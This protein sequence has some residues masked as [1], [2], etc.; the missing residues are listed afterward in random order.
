MSD[1]LLAAI[2]GVIE[3]LTEFLPVS[4]TAHL[5][6]S[7]VLMGINLKDPYWEMFSIVIQTGAILAVPIYFWSTIREFLADFPR[8]PRGRNTLLTHPLTL[9][10][11]AFVFT[12][13]PSL[14]LR[15]VIGKNLESIRAMAGALVIGGIIMWV[16]DVLCARPDRPSSTE[17]LDE[18]GLFQ[19]IWIGICQA[20]SAIFPGTSR[21]MATISGGQMAGMSRPV[22]LEFSFLLAIPT[23]LAAGAFDLLRSLREK[24]VAGEAAALQIGSPHGIV[25]LLIGGAVAFAVAYLSVAWFMQWV[26]RHGFVPFAVYRIAVGALLLLYASRL[27]G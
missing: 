12:A 9:M 25:L 16:V 18:I 26:R 4:S 10:A 17:N 23:M 13:G 15:K 21:S 24:P 27:G 2:L 5:R 7:E 20:L 14:L 1:Y 3:G 11:V 8:G 6:I 22:A 19:A